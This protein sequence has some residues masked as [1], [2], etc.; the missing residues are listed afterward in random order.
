MRKKNKPTIG[1]IISETRHSSD[2]L[3]RRQELRVFVRLQEANGQTTTNYDGVFVDVEV[4]FVFYDDEYILAVPGFN[5]VR[6][7]V[8][9]KLYKHS[10]NTAR[11]NY[12]NFMKRNKD[13]YDHT[14][15]ELL[16]AVRRHYALASDVCPTV[17][18]MSIY[19]PSPYRLPLTLNFVLS[20]AHLRMH[21]INHIMDNPED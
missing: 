18:P 3:L 19:S 21:K 6:R 12:D 8:T 15:H 10:D 11:L 5:P 17:V 16:E 4:N 14:L 2:V 13:V 1:K 7:A 9:F 20:G